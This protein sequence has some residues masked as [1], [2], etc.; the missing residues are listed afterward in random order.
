MEYLQAQPGEDEDTAWKRMRP[1]LSDTGRRLDE[2][3][4]LQPAAVPGTGGAPPTPPYTPPPGGA[5]GLF[6]DPSGTPTPAPG[7][8]APTPGIF[9]AGT[10]PGSRPRVR[11]NN[12]ATSP[13]NL[14]GKIE[15]WGIGPATP[16]TE[17]T[18]KV[19]A[20]TGAQLKELLKKLPDGMTFEL[21]LEKEGN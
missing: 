16:L 1:K 3:F 4:L 17:V 5:G 2:V 21:D 14:F 11:L 10:T 12:P 19:S 6:G 15:E 7:S 20:A 8:P 9:G 18:I 13:L